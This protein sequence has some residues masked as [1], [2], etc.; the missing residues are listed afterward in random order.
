[1]TSFCNKLEA[2]IRAQD[3]F[4]IPVQL[5]YKGESA[6]NTTCGG[7]VSMIFVFCFVVGFFF[8]LRSY[9]LEPQFQ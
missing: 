5:T 8:E 3:L 4:G 2:K 6:F 1:M 9:W 7:C